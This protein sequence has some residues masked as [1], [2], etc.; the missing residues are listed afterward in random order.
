MITIIS[1]LFLQVI[2]PA[3]RTP[4]AALRWL[5]PKDTE[6][7]PVRLVRE[8]SGVLYVEAKHMQTR[9]TRP[10]KMTIAAVLSTLIPGAS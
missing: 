3:V 8:I 5:L 10:M 7:I 2:I 9:R 6:E 4:T 1:Y